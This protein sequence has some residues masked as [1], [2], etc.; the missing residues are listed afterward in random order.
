M[1]GQIAMPE[2]SRARVLNIPAQG[3]CVGLLLLLYS[4]AIFAGEWANEQWA[5]RALGWLALILAALPVVYAKSAGRSAISPLNIF[6]LSFWLFTMGQ[7]LLISIGIEEFWGFDIRH[8]F[9]TSQITVASLYTLICLVSFYWGAL[10]AERHVEKRMERRGIVEEESIFERAGSVGRVILVVTLVPFLVHQVLLLQHASEIGYSAINDIGTHG[11]TLM[12]KIFEYTTVYFRMSVFL[13]LM[14]LRHNKARFDLFALIFLLHPLSLL[15]TGER[16]E[17]TAMIL[18][19]IWLRQVLF[20]QASVRSGLL[21]AGG[22]VVLVVSYPAIM[23]SRADGIV[24]PTLIWESIR[25]FG[26]VA[27]IADGIAIIGYSIYPLI[28]TMSLVPFAEDFRLGLTYATALTNVV[29]YIGFAKEHSTLGLWLMDELHMSYGPGFSIPA[30]AY[31][32]FGWFPVPIMLLI[33]YV[34][35]RFVYIKPYGLGLALSLVVA[36][37]FLLTNVTLPRREIVGAVRDLLYVML[38]IYLLVSGFFRSSS[39]AARGPRRHQKVNV[40]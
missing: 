17:S 18:L 36:C 1:N 3:V 31:I 38:P 13:I 15:V 35:G 29:P 7:V 11:S 24:T 19:L 40:H 26:F 10:I 28:Q 16:T 39:A 30:E 27:S 2:T 21:M 20:G 5:L 22:A 37:A 14:S 12:M 23:A 6:L 34:F 4:W 8:H 32:N 25:E 9:T 33:G